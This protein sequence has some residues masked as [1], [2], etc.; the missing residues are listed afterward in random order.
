[1]GS[2]A[3]VEIREVRSE[4][5][6][7]TWVAV[8]NLASPCRPEG[9][10]SLTH[11]WSTAPEWCAAIAW[12]DGRPV[13]VA[14][15][16]VEQW[17][18]TSRHAETTILVPRE[19]RHG[20]VGTALYR[21]VS[22]WAA[23]RDREGLDVWFDVADRDATAYWE[24]RGFAEVGREWVSHLDLR[25]ELPAAECPPGIRLV[26]LAERSDLDEDMYRIGSEGIADIPNVEPYAAGDFARWRDAELG[27]PGLMR[28]CSVVALAG[29]EVVGYAILVRF[30]ARPGFAEHE[31]T[32]VARAWRGRGL[33]SAMKARQIALA[34]AAGLTTLEAMNEERN[35]SMLAVNVRLGY[36]PITAYVQVRGP[37]AGSVR[38]PR[39]TRS[40]RFHQHPSL[41]AV[42]PGLRGRRAEDHH[43][44][45]DREGA[46]GLAVHQPRPDR[47][48]GGLDEQQE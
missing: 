11:L 4:A 21:A 1:M 26:T 31:M 45:G 34:G 35:A 13:G 25:S 15:V 19:E 30:E 10:R 24:A 3:T 18:P 12:R 32:A 39:R 9:V 5:D 38:A 23:E 44:A 36:R 29:S 7:A 14:H 33:A 46:D 43:S 48:E 20:G 47:V 16:E 42:P 17:S 6:V 28:E 22:R 27:R 37:L 8:H 2:F 41:P 40:A